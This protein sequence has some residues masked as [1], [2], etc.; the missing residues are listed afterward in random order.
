[1]TC[2]DFEERLQE[3]LDLRCAELPSEL[4]AHSAA[5]GT[6]RQLLEQFRCMDSAVV[7]WRSDCPSI[8]LSA[9]VLNQLGV[10]VDHAPDTNSSLSVAAAVVASGTNVQS[11]RSTSSVGY[12][13]PLASAVALL[14]MLGLGWHAS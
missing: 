7:A 1:M 12:V 10:D 3:L 8:D 13:A 11:P 2:F 5:C 6:C 14:G 4:L 9:S